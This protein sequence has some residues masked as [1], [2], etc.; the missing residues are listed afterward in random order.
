MDKKTIIKFI[1][2]LMLCIGLLIFNIIVKNWLMVVCITII[3]ICVL[4][5]YLKELFKIDIMILNKNE[6]NEIESEPE[7]IKQLIKDTIRNEL[8]NIILDISKFILYDMFVNQG[9]KADD[10]GMIA[11]EDDPDNGQVVLYLCKHY[12]FLI[13]GDRDVKTTE[14]LKEGDMSICVIKS[15]EVLDLANVTNFELNS[16]Y[17]LEDF[18]DMIVADAKGL[19]DYVDELTEIYKYLKVSEEDLENAQL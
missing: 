12:I 7:D 17:Y 6:L 19:S 1:I 3:T 13:S 11:F 4:Y 5:L 14:P 2:S 9:K 18:V 10:A 15:D 8:I 16:I